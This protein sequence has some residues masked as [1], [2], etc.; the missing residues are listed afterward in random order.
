M[1]D[2]R[3][4]WAAGIRPHPTQ[5]IPGIRSSGCEDQTDESVA[6]RMDMRATALNPLP[7]DDPAAIREGPRTA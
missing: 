5:V 2:S 6:L 4:T 1:Y 3:D 7:D